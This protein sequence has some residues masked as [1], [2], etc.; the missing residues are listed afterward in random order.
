MRSDGSF[1][2]KSDSRGSEVA[3]YHNARSPRPLLVCPPISFGCDRGRKGIESADHRRSRDFRGLL[4]GSSNGA[5]S[6]TTIIPNYIKCCRW[7]G[8]KARTIREV[9]MLGTIPGFHPKAAWRTLV[10]IEVSDL[11]G[12]TEIY[13]LPVRI[14]GDDDR[15][16]QFPA[17]DRLLSLNAPGATPSST[18]RP[19][20]P[21]FAQKFNASFGSNKGDSA[22]TGRSLARQPAPFATS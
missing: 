10:L 22:R 15:S 5:I 9:Q 14:V 4:S 7:F 19:S 13:T 6:S 21:I 16:P 11:E 8:A 2:P 20:I 17:K 3:L 1:Q 12:P 18:T